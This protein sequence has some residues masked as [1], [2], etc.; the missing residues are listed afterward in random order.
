MP[1]QLNPKRQFLENKADADAFVNLMAQP[2]M[3]RALTFA[4]AEYAQGPVTGQ[5][6]AGVRKFIEIF[7]VLGEENSGPGSMPV[8]ALE[9]PSYTM[10]PKKEGKT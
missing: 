3:R 6:I 4:L 1:L 8:K 9:S 10:E 5:E 7:S 2:V